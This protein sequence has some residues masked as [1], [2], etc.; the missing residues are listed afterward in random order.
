MVIPESE[1][2]LYPN[3]LY[4]RNVMPYGRTCR[5]RLSVGEAPILRSR[6]ALENYRIQSSTSSDTS[7]SPL[8]LSRCYM[9]L[10][11]LAP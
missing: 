6:P 2:L 11:A 3:S 10:G 9:P 8:L 5:N 1:K 4:N 7:C